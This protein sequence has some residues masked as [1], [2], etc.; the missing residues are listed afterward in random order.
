MLYIVTYLLMLNL[1]GSG[2]DPISLLILLLFFLLLLLGNGKPAPYDMSAA[3]F[4]VPVLGRRT[5]IVCH[6]PNSFCLGELEETT[7]MPP[8][9][10]DED[11]AAGPGIIEPLNSTQL[12]FIETQ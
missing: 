11:Y 3:M 1:F 2:T 7:G 9:Y 4:L 8:Y 12:N 5:W 10:V 6:G